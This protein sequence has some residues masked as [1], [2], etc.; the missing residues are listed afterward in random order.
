MSLTH[1]RSRR[2]L[3]DA[4]VRVHSVR[5]GVYVG[6]RVRLRWVWVGS[7]RLSWGSWSARVVYAGG[8]VR[9]RWGSGSLGW[10]RGLRWGSGRLRSFMLAFGFFRIDSGFTLGF[11]M[12]G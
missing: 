12:L 11:G 4:A 1:Y 9:L 2:R 10:T 5:F 6:V 7:G 3:V 8:R